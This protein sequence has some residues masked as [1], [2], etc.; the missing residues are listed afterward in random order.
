LST[1]EVYPGLKRELAM[2][3]GGAWDISNVQ[4]SD[5]LRFSRAV[6]VPWEQ[7]RATLLELASRLHAAASKTVTTSDAAYVPSPIYDQLAT[8]I[9]RHTASLERALGV[10]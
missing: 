2:K 6:D 5:W 3:L 10:R 1:E 8:V 4:R 7:V 9:A